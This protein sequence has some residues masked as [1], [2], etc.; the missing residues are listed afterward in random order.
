MPRRLLKLAQLQPHVGTQLGVEV[1]K[2]FVEQ[3]HGRRE[4]EGARQRDP[5]LLA[6]GQLRGAAFPI[7]AHLHHVERGI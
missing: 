4:H 5:L 3:Q 1:R 2:R 7:V 6:A